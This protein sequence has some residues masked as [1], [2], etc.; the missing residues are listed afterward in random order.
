[1]PIV[2]IGHFDDEGADDCALAAA[3]LCRDRLVIDRIPVFDPK[4]VAT[5]APSPTPTPFPSPAPEGLF[6]P[7]AP[8]VCAGDVK[9]S[10]VGWVLSEELDLA[11]LSQGYVWAAVT[12]DDVLLGG[13]QW[14]EDPE[15]GEEFRWWGRR[16][17]F[18]EEGQPD[19]VLYDAVEGTTY[20]ELRDGT[21]T[22][23]DLP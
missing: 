22:K 6:D 19:V 2:V 20:K 9:Y 17:C 14:T 13:N 11:E 5:P 1:V 18:A 4:S 7:K 3:K 15:T 23:V 12:A 21:R 10:F 8:R 16:I